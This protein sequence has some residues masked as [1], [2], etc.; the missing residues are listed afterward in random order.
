MWRTA[1][2]EAG[3]Q[4]MRAPSAW[5]RLS[6]RG[7][8]EGKYVAAEQKTTYCKRASC[9]FFFFHSERARLRATKKQLRHSSSLLF[10][11]PTLT[12]IIPSKTLN[13]EGCLLF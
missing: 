9:D 6:T 13:P 1:E 11:M 12:K 3:G 5:I 4:C 2:T 8:K 7:P 10:N